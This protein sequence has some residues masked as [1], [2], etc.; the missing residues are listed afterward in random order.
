MG[1]TLQKGLSMKTTECQ[2]T[3]AANP[4]PLEP[5]YYW[6]GITESWREEGIPEH[7]LDEDEKG[8]YPPY[9]LVLVVSEKNGY[10]AGEIWDYFALVFGNLRYSIADDLV[11]RFSLPTDKRSLEGKEVLKEK[12]EQTLSGRIDGHRGSCLVA[13]GEKIPEKNTD[14][15]PALE[16][17]LKAT[18]SAVQGDLADIKELLKKQEQELLDNGE[19]SDEAL[20][21]WFHGLALALDACK[22]PLYLLMPET[23]KALSGWLL[24]RFGTQGFPDEL[25]ETIEKEL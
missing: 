3:S 19:P 15:R 8:E 9:S 18:N 5:G 25:I 22:A 16:A 7:L 17:A 24:G 10:L 11:K 21:F 23:L 1:R 4:W 6:L 20:F 12:I 14:L 13:L 2:P